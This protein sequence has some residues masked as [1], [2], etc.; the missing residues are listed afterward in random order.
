MNRELAGGGWLLVD[1]PLPTD[2]SL[3]GEQILINS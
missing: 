2:G 1:I 3:N